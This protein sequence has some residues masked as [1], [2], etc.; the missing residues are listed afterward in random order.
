MKESQFIY[1]LDVDKD[2]VY[3]FKKVVEDLG[4]TISVFIDGYKMIYELGNLAKLP[5]VIFLNSN[6]PVLNG[7]EILDIIKG[8][9]E[10]KQI[11]IVM[12]SGAFPRK[13]LRYYNHV[14]VNHILKRPISSDYNRAYDQVFKMDLSQVLRMNSNRNVKYSLSL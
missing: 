12:V 7:E 4:H 5:D 14:G 1:Y 8:N 11:S 3:S 9:E 6:M 10:W 2:D 13:L